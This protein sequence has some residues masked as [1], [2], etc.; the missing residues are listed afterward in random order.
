MRGGARTRS[1]AEPYCG[2]GY[3]NRAT[4]AVYRDVDGGNTMNWKLNVLVVVAVAFC[5]SQAHACGIITCLLT[6][7]GTPERAKMDE[8]GHSLRRAGRAMQ[9]IAPPPWAPPPRTTRC[10]PVGGGAFQCQTY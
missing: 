8:I 6:Q 9:Q 4:A 2:S 1:R 10:W 5:A 3:H 7:P